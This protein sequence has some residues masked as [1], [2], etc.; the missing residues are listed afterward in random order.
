[1]TVVLVF[2]NSCINPFIYAAKYREFQHGVRRLASCIGIQAH[3]QAPDL[4]HSD[5]PAVSGSIRLSINAIA[6]R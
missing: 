6:Q 5:H 2:T 1:M 3:Q 4:N